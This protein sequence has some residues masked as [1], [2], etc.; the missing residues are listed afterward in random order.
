MIEIPSILKYDPIPL[1]GNVEKMFKPWWCIALIEGEVS[2]Y[3]SW[4][5]LK[6]T[7]IRIQ[8]PAWGSHVSICRGEEPVNKD[9]WKRHDGE[10]LIMRYDPDVRTNGNHWWMRIEC[11]GML[12]IREEL[13]LPR[14]GRFNLHMTLGMPI[15]LHKETSDYYHN[16]FKNYYIDKSNDEQIN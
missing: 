7:G 9:F 1:S 6:R 11:E 4:F 12:D 5:V 8:R 14:H 10:T 3:Y 16:Y 15:P 13:G 2:E